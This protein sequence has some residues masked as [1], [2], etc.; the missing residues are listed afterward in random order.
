MPYENRRRYK[1][2]GK[3]LE[4]LKEDTDEKAEEIRQKNRK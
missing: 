3:Y 4:E 1:K 2:T